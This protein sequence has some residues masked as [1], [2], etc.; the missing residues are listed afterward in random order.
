MTRAVLKSDL[1]PDK[2]VEVDER[3][4]EIVESGS[5]LVPFP[6]IADAELRRT[7]LYRK[8]ECTIG[9]PGLIH[10]FSVGVPHPANLRGM[11]ILVG[12]L[13]LGNIKSV[14]QIDP[15]RSGSP[16]IIGGPVSTSEARLIFGT[17]G[18]SPLLQVPLP[19]SFRYW[20]L[21]DEAMQ[22]RREPWQLLVDGASNTAVR[23]CL[24]ITNLPV[25]DKVDRIVNIAGLHAEGTIALDW[26]LRD[27]RLLERLER[28]TRNLDGW[29]FFAEVKMDRSNR[30]L[31]LGET[32][33]REITGAKFDA[34][35]YLRL[36][37]SLLADQVGE[38]SGT[39]DFLWEYSDMPRGHAKGGIAGFS[40]AGA[41]D[42]SSGEK[43]ATPRVSEAW[44]Q[45]LEARAADAYETG[46]R[47]FEPLR[48]ELERAHWGSYVVINTENGGYVVAPSLSE[49]RKSFLAK[50]GRAQG[51][52]TRIGAPI[53]AR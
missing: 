37:Q 27:T 6:S 43:S 45:N 16:T 4:T 47:L 10:P 46:E 26:V 3:S 14:P 34:T 1:T 8:S 9:K 31:S 25:S 29:Q 22:S 48:N 7:V 52:C 5:Q 15:T 18:S 41:V 32:A 40:A 51:W 49:A 17:G 33:I 38:A 2:V 39:E 21:M 19:F 36:S 30:P 28:D 12:R 24:I 11:G 13:R 53:L 44:R 35:Q 42:L 20:E 23:E 50:H